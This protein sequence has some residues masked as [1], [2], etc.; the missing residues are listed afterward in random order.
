MKTIILTRS[1]VLM[2][3]ISF[4]V[5]YS[6]MLSMAVLGLRRRKPASDAARTLA[7]S[8]PPLLLSAVNC[9]SAGTANLETALVAATSLVI[10]QVGALSRR[11][12]YA[13]LSFISIVPLLL[14]GLGLGKFVCACQVPIIL[15]IALICHRIQSSGIKSLSG[16]FTAYEM[17]AALIIP[18]SFSVL[19]SSAAFATAVSFRTGPLA[20]FVKLAFAV[21]IASLFA[22]QFLR[23]IAG[24]DLMPFRR[25]LARLEAAS[26][27]LQE[28][29]LV[30]GPDTCLRTIYC[31]FLNL[32]EE[33]ELFLDPSLNIVDAARMIFTNRNYLGKAISVY[34]GRNY[35]SL[36]NSYRIRYAVEAFRKNPYL[37]IG[38]MVEMSGFRTPGSFT[39]AFRLEMKKSPSEWCNEYRE[40]HVK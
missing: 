31:R 16:R 19:I 33:K 21:L 35:C 20:E 38:Q 4:L 2:S 40:S 37:R 30:S 11:L 36:V 32:M 39:L 25:R 17:F 10:C 6:T 12:R 9:L 13:L 27:E 24:R 26:R 29:E 22:I 5:F 3:D 8:V 7:P 34:G 1:A 18:L 15:S 23:F 14:Y 28:Q